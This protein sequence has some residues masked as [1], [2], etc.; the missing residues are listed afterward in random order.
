MPKTIDWLYARK[1]CE[2]CQTALAY[3]ND[4]AVT[5][6]E[7]VDGKVVKY[8][9]ADIPALLA[10]VTKL[11]ATRGK[12]VVTFDLKKDKPDD[13]TLLAHLI[14]P[15]G[16]LRAPTVRVGKTMLVGFNGEAYAS[17]LG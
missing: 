4:R 3:L 7:R 15:R 16:T 13:A 5:V 1:H 6:V 10:N 9:P 11:I 8:G 17:V 14:G 2:T 12:K